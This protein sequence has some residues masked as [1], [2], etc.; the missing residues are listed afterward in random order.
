MTVA[1]TL[2]RP[3]GDRGNP[4]EPT[5]DY[6]GYSDSNSE[7]GHKLLLLV[8]GVHCG[9]C[10]ARIER[11]LKKEPDVESARLNLSTRRLALTWQGSAA[12]ANDLAGV[13]GALGYRVVPVREADQSALEGDSRLLR[14]MAI[15]GFAAANVMLLSIAVWAGLGHGMGTA[16]RDLLHWFSALIALPAIVYA[17]RPFFYSAAAA[18]RGWGTNMDVPISL[19]IILTSG[20]SLFETARGG[21]HTYFDSAVALLFFLLLGRYLDSRARGK[22]RETASRLMALGARAVTALDEDGKPHGLPVDEV[23]AGMRLLVASGERIPADGVVLT[24]RSEIDSSLISGETLPSAAGPGDQVYAGTINIGAP[25]T[26]RVSAVGEGT[27]LAEIVRLLEVAEQRRARYV[28]L[29]DRVARLYAPVVH[30]L[31]LATFLGWLVLGGLAWQASLLI[32]VAV[33]IITCPCA[34]ALAVP[35]VQVVASGRLM[36]QGTLLKSATALERLARVDTVVFDKTGTLTEGRAILQPGDASEADL[37]VA[38]RLAGASR[39]PLAKALCSAGSGVAPAEG[40]RETPGSGLALNT[41]AGEIRLGSRDWCDV[42]D[43]APAEGPELWL[44]RPDSAPVCFRFSDQP[45][46][47]AGE[48]IASLKQSGFGV[49][50][51]SGDRRETVSAVA[52]ELGIADWQAELKPAEKVAALEV[53]AA[54]GRRVLMVGDGLNDAPALA[55]AYV[56]LSPS[57]A[58]DISQTAADAVFQGQ[59]L[60]PVTDSLRVA[61]QADRLVKQNFGL[62]F[63]YNAITIPLAVMGFVTPLFAALAMSSSSL[64]VVGNA[65]RLG[66]GRRR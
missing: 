39:H 57:S 27:L 33:L 13:V 64:V 18:L 1:A 49:A 14:S 36:R 44:V 17:G 65:L 15:A 38:A 5:F 35:V 53:L 21:P 23:A 48:I 9:G 46:V 43:K 24:G 66:L 31:A 45:R 30:G 58:A 12:R 52:S 32:A 22:A 63:G 34:L 50:L 61:R 54:K 51:L 62:A 56:S 59:R 29:A 37:R 26:L 2:E 6:A 19:A 4:D 55:A 25:L 40:V 42:R 20:M 7:G 16:T 60:A 47:D 10:I 41:Q 3:A 8:D 28:A 11:A